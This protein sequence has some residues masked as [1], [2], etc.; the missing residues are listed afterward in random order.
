MSVVGLDGITPLL[1]AYSINPGSRRQ[2]SLK[3]ASPG[4]NITTKSGASASSFSVVFRGELFCRADLTRVLIEE[5]GAFGFVRFFGGV[6]IGLERRF[7]VD[8]DGFVAGEVD[9]Q[10]WAEAAVG[11]GDARLF[12]EVAVFDHAGKLHHA[13]QLHLAPLPADLGRAEGA[14]E[15]L[16]FI[17]QLLALAHQA[18]MLVKGGVAGG[19]LF[20]ERGE[21]G[22]HP[23]ESIA[24]GSTLVIRARKQPGE[25]RSRQERNDRDQNVVRHRS[26][27]EVLLCS[28]K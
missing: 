15:R 16:G 4:R 6:E 27:V 26:T 22:T 13:A 19:A 12:D 2:A 7:G 20:F 23:R 10:V 25:G 17:G 14:D 5:R 28:R 8:D 18:Q 3:N 21:L 9:D 1:T 11:G 24:N